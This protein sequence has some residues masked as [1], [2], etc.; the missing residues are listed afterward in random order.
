LKNDSIGFS[1][2]LVSKWSNAYIWFSELMVIGYYII[3]SYSNY[4][5]GHISLFQLSHELITSHFYS[6]SS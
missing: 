3:E 4:S 2:F 1:F 5:S 6:R